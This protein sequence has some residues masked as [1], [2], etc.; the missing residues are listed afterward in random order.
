MMVRKYWSLLCFQTIRQ[1]DGRLE[2]LLSLDECVEARIKE[3]MREELQRPQR[4]NGQTS[5]AHP[6]EVHLSRV[7]S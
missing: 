3:L 1:K 4:A 6:G 5:G 2:Q 7:N